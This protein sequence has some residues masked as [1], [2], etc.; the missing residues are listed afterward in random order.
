MVGFVYGVIGILVSMLNIG[1]SLINGIPLSFFYVVFS[2]MF[3]G[4]GIVL[5]GLSLTK[6]EFYSFSFREKRVEIS[7]E[8]LSVL[9][10]FSVMLVI[11][12]SS[13]I[14]DHNGEYNLPMLLIAGL[15]GLKYRIL[16][17]KSFII[18]VVFFAVLVEVSAIFSGLYVEGLYVLL[19][20][21]FFFG[22]IIILYQDDLKR[23]FDLAKKYHNKLINLE[24]IVKKFQGETL[25][26]ST[27]NFTP[28]ELEVLKE[29]CLSRATNQELAD[30]MGLKVQTIKTHLRNIFDKSGV[31]DRYQLIDLFKH[32]YVE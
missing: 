15:M 20:S 25:D 13:I 24:K 28:R 17:G 10:Q 18:M 2:G 6:K 8:R 29:I 31:D 14:E 16:G 30:S 3:S 32:N 12:I 27:I 22:I 1:L 9:I 5:L 7:I 23:N 11:C 26:I 19:F 4:V 21:T